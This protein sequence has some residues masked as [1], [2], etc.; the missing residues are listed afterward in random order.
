M[1]L[2]HP[3]LLGPFRFLTDRTSDR[4]P[5]YQHYAMLDLSEF[6]YKTHYKGL[7]V[8]GPILASAEGFVLSHGSG[9]S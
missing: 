2:D 6:G 3:E 5:R 9:I 1:G 8:P 7:G 4:P